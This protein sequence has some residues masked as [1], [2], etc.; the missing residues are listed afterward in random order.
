MTKLFRVGIS[1]GLFALL[2]ACAGQGWSGKDAMQF[3]KMVT[4]RTEYY[5]TGPEQAAPPEGRFDE[6]TRIRII[7]PDGSF[8]KV[9][10]AS[11][12]TAYISADAIG[13]PPAE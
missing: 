13:E 11:G 8:V 12:T 9:Q 2:A 4:K 5:L 10:S 7:A 1:I 6:G 3:D